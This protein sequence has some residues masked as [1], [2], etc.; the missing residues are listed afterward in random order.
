MFQ[1]EIPTAWQDGTGDL[2][3]VVF[4]EKDRSGKC[5][6]PAGAPETI[7]N[8]LH[9]FGHAWCRSYLMDRHGLDWLAPSLRKPWLDEG[10][11]DY[12]AY[13]REP[14]FL[15]RRMDWLLAEKVAKG[16]PPPAYRELTDYGEFYDQGD[17]D[18]HY[19]LSALLVAEILGTEER[20]VPLIA[21]LLDEIGR[22]RDV[23]A[24]VRRVTRKDPAR[25]FERLTAR[26]WGPPE[27]R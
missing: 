21:R 17:I 3:I 1:V 20:G 8:V 2:N 9:E 11:A 16:A 18:S 13:L 22:T 24:A 12:I 7:G 27:S 26:L 14:K 5:S 25:E 4:C 23:E 6:R 19:W 15:K 10:L